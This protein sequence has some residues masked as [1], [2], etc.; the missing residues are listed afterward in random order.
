M[1]GR[2]E[3][4]L[5]VYE[6]YRL[7]DQIRWY[8]NRIREFEA[9][10][11]QV[12]T[13]SGVLLFLASAAGFLAASDFLDMRTWW[14]ILAAVF[15]ACSAAIASYSTLIGFEH[16]AKL[17]GDAAAA[18]EHLRAD[19]P[20]S[21]HLPSGAEA[22]TTIGGFVANVEAVFRKEAGQWGQLVASSRPA[23]HAGSEADTAEGTSPE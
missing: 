10:R 6:R 15:S 4:V 14:A 13:L 9:A 21:A 20:D 1:N 5:A 3:Q 16:V 19:M 8:E 7:I 2:N 12:I 18:L 17:Y 23:P 11:S 22:D